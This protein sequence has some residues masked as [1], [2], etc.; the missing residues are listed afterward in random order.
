MRRIWQPDV[1]WQAFIESMLADPAFTIG[2]RC[3][4][5][6]WTAGS[7]LFV[8]DQCK[9][10][11]RTVSRNSSGASRFAQWPQPAMICNSAPGTSPAAR[12]TASIGTAVSFS[13]WMNKVGTAISCSRGVKS[14]RTLVLLISLLWK[15]IKAFPPP[16]IF[17]ASN[18]SS[19]NSF[20][21]LFGS[22]IM[23]LARAPQSE[24][25]RFLYTLNDNSF[26]HECTYSQEIKWYL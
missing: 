11:S 25:L 12:F 2:H 23:P 20:V 10:N 16:G 1:V 18:N 9:R 3:N 6:G 7:D 4:R 26:S 17:A 13:P 24:T 5:P 22:W 8:V 19:N 21:S 15:D 14:V